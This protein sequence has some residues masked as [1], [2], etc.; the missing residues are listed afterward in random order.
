M[1]KPRITVI[2]ATVGEKELTNC[3]KSVFNQGN[4]VQHLVVIDG[5]EKKAIKLINNLLFTY[6]F[7]AT[8]TLIS[9][10]KDGYY[11]HRIYAAFSLLVDTEFVAF[12]DEDCTLEPDW[13]EKMLAHAD[14]NPDKIIT[15]RRNLVHE[16]ELLGVDNR[17]SIGA[18]EFG[19]HLHDV[20]TYLLPTKHMVNITRLLYDKWGM[21][22]RLAFALQDNIYHTTEPLVNYAVREDRL[23]FYSMIVK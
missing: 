8:Q 15:C 10:G 6:D 5:K 14:V 3:V 1:V 23:D 22:R 2:T 20:N 18:N 21:D 4:L 17:E 19:Y 11:G 13:A 7:M 12:L 9:T 16:G